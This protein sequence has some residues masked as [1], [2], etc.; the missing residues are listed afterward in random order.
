MKTAAMKVAQGR[1]GQGDMPLL[2]PQEERALIEDLAAGGMPPLTPQA[3]GSATKPMTISQ[4]NM[5][6]SQALAAA[7]PP[8]FFVQGEISNFRTY[9]RG[10]A[11]F[12][13]KDA[14]AELPCILWKDG[15]ARL[16]FRPKDGLAVIARGAVR[17]Y[18]PQGKIQLYVETMFPQG[19]GALELAFRQLCEKL[20]AEGL[21]EPARKR[22]IPRL[23]RHVVI[24]T[25]RTGDVLHDVLTTAWRR[26]P[27]LFVSLY[28]VRV[29]GEQA[30]PDIVRAIERVNGYSE[31]ASSRQQEAGIDLMLLVR[32]GG[33]LED[34]WAFNEESVARA[35]VASRIA[36]ATGIGHEPDTTIA[37]LVGDLRG[38]TP[39]GVT[40]LTI[41]DAK[42]LLGDLLNRAA[43]L[44]R[45]V[46][47]TL[48]ISQ[49]DLE[50]VAVQ[51]TAAGAEMVRGRR[52]TIEEWCKQIERIEPRHAI[53]QGWRRVEEAQRR[54]NAGTRTGLWQC[55]DTLNSLALRLERC[56]PKTAL[57][58]Q[59]DHVTV[60]EATLRR[61][62][63]QRLAAARQRLAAAE[64]QLRVVSPEAVLE[65]GFSITTDKDG[66]IVRAP[67]QVRRGDVIKTQTAKGTI[68]STVGK[69]RQGSLF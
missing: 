10:H 36:I 45:D 19:A 59:R 13:L 24:I 51:L 52:V 28:P 11:F 7:L 58:R 15:L 33:S 42:A 57:L 55:D 44:T 65:R 50:R 23:P 4:A 63:Q 18:E 21:F 43:L 64:T 29:Q 35:I 41:P 46:C 37:D 6:L 69:P 1:K 9:D 14:A 61:A 68:H 60:L 66:Q 56:T 12:T 31:E 32:G 48:T 16:K 67:D 22:P 8:V 40:E 20:R 26:Y 39:T 54:L 49:G 47:R 27:G 34:L 30:A 53:A 2:S 25:S 3:T 38:P 5:L 62:L 17:L